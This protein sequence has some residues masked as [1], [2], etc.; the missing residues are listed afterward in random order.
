M[1]STASVR[2]KRLRHI[3]TVSIFPLPQSHK[4]IPLEK[5]DIL[6]YHISVFFYNIYHTGPLST[7]QCLS[8]FIVRKQ[9]LENNKESK[10]ELSKPSLIIAFAFREGFI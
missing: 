5:M 4:I 2:A 8:S 3:F 1:A 7:H 9:L 6:P 10:E